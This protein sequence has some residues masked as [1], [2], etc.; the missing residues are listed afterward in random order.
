MRLRIRE[1]G[2]HLPRNNHAIGSIAH[3]PFQLRQMIFSALNRGLVRFWFGPIQRWRVLGRNIMAAR[4]SQSRP[5]LS[6]S[7]KL[8]FN[9]HRDDILILVEEN[10]AQLYASEGQQRTVA[11]ALKIAQARVFMAEENRPPLL[12]IDDIFGELDPIRRNLLLQHLP[13]ESQKLVTA[14]TMQWRE[15]GMEGPVFELNEHR[16]YRSK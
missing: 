3:A 12:L 8:R 15:N 4:E 16:I 2:V 9:P 5:Q 7:D 6:R 11:L 10:P 13:E 1:I 14:T